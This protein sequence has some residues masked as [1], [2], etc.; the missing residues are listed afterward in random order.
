MNPAPNL[1][2]I[3]PMGAGKSSIGKQLAVRLGLEF[4]DA[5]RRVEQLAG[6]SVPMIFELEGEAGF[7]QREES[8]MTELMQG[9]G[10]VVASGGGAIL[11]DAVRA[12][13]RSRSFVVYLQLGVEQQLHRLAR[14][15]S[16]PLLAGGDRR[17]KLQALAAVRNP[18]YEGLADLAFASDGLGVGPA[19]KRICALVAAQ[20]RREEAA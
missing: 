4:V 2:L 6:A 10:R 13:L 20:W 8:V 14:D 5:D 3:G 12:L 1:V 17:Q 7:R 19:S 18:L 16:R 11:S 9:A 15:R